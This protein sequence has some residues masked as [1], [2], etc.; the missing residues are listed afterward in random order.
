MIFLTYFCRVADIL[1]EVSPGIEALGLECECV[2]GGRI[3]H[4]SEKSLLVYGYSVV[5]MKYIY[6]RVTHI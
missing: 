5:S 4:K 3:N 2:G 6:V 1:D